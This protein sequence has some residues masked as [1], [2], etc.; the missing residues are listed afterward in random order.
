MKTNTIIL[1]LLSILFLAAV[2]TNPNLERH[3][4]VIKGKVIVH[5]QKSV[6]EGLNDSSNE[7]KQAGQAIGMM[8][9]GVFINGLLDNLVTTDNYVLFSTTKISWQGESRV[10]GIGVF[11]NVFITGEFEKTLNEGL[12]EK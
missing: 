5:L 8:L 4:E 3:K 9:G 7:W 6:K 11:G 1:F 12:L 2:L 10:I